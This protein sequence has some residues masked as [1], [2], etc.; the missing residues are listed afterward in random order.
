[1]SIDP[2]SLELR[3]NPLPVGK[4]DDDVYANKRTKRLTYPGDFENAEK[5]SDEE[6]RRYMSVLQKSLTD[7]RKQ[8]RK[9]AQTNRRQQ[10][11][12]NKLKT[13]LKELIDKTKN[14]N[15]IIEAS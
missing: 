1:M 9:L 5:L 12:I 11:R 13:M 15:Y 8:S 14:G 2:Q 4:N 6:T 3:N 7:Q 10:E